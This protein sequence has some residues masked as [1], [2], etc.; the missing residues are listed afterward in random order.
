MGAV[1]GVALNGRSRPPLDEH[2][3]SLLRMYAIFVEDDSDEND[4]WLKEPG[5]KSKNLVRPL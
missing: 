4:K 5:I 3:D 1:T 2:L